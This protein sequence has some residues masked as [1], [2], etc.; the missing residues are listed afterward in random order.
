MRLHFEKKGSGNEYVMLFPGALGSSSTDFLPQ[1]EKF[2]SSDFTLFAW[3]PPGYGKSRPPH[4]PWPDK[5]FQKDADSAVSL[6]KAIDPDKK[7]NLLGWSDGG[8]TSLIVAG[9]HPEIVRK[10]VV[11]GA[12]AYV[13]AKDIMLY[14][15]VR[16]VTAWSDRMRKPYEDVYGVEYFKMEWNNWKVIQILNKL[17]TICKNTSSN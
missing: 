4:R 13:T 2:N 8:I 3:D 5:Y 16:D 6:M 9:N 7:W 10:L 1:M 14:E 11:W 17:L 12:N 15:K